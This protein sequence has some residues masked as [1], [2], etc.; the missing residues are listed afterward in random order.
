LEKKVAEKETVKATV[1]NTS[2]LAEAAVLMQD[3]EE[4]APSP[5]PIFRQE[6]EHKPVFKNREEVAVEKGKNETEAAR[7]NGEKLE[8]DIRG[9]SDQVKSPFPVFKP[10]KTEGVKIPEKAEQ[11][12]IK[13]V[14][15]VKG[16]IESK[17]IRLVEEKEL[18]IQPE[19][20]EENKAR[21]ALNVTMSKEKIDTIVMQIKESAEMTMK[22]EEE[23][24]REKI[25]IEER[26][27]TWQS[28]SKI[29]E[30]SQNDSN[31]R[32]LKK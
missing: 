6:T 15:E 13:E 27:R 22:Q 16:I 28:A 2:I 31:K 5:F 23:A 1:A 9:Q 4:D 30:S 26:V 14:K 8:K 17:E 32:D 12:E 29:T 25:S 21:I 20:S 19:T 3:K 10:E 7:E 24:W 18:G 11:K